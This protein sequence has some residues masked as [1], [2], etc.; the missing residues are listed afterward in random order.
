MKVPQNDCSQT[1]EINNEFHF[2]SIH[3]IITKSY[4]TDNKLI[5]GKLPIS[6]MIRHITTGQLTLN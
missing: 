3:I 6:D 1:Y 4:R 2:H 5:Q